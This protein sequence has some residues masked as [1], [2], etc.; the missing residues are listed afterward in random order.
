MVK[1]G[2]PGLTTGKVWLVKPEA[3]TLVRDAGNLKEEFR[4]N[5]QI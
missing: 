2:K 4:K 1:S 3:S 5:H